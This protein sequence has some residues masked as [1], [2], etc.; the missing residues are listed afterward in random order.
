MDIVID[1]RGDV[2]IYEQI[3]VQIASQF[4]DGRLE[5]GELLPSIRMIA[6]ELGISVITLKKA[7]ELLEADDLIYTRAGKGS[8][9]A[10]HP[11]DSLSAKRISLAVE[12]FGQEAPY[13]RALSITADELIEIILGEC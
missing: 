11:T 10:A 6:R 1:E 2:P 12:R 9:V 4:P 8:F 13:F 7:W 5:P 3:H